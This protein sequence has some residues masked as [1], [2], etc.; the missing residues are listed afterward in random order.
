MSQNY[1]ACPPMAFTQGLW[2]ESATQK[3]PLGTVRYGP[4]GNAYVYAK[5]GASALTVAHI[6]SAP[7]VDGVVEATVTVAH[8][9]GTKDVTVTTV[10]AVT[11][12]QYAEGY[13]W[14]NQGTGIGDTYRIAGNEVA[15]GAAATTFHLETGLRTAWSASDTDITYFPNLYGGVLLKAYATTF[16][17]PVGVATYTVTDA[18]YAWLMVRGYTA[19]KIDVAAGTVGEEADEH[20]VVPSPNHA[21]QGLIIEA[22]ATPAGMYTVGEYCNHLSCVDND[23]EL[24]RVTL[25]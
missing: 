16:Y 8:A 1:S 17:K 19:I 10:G 12:D 22:G 14:V 2:E 3:H 5:A 23:A 9:I 21:G 25:L 4:E 20:I 15:S 13:L 7:I 18:Y 24:C 6:G 11:K